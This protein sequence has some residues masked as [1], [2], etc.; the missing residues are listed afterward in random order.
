M[1]LMAGAALSRCSTQ[2][3]LMQGIS[4]LQSRASSSRRAMQGLMRMTSS[5]GRLH[6]G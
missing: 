3:V 2:P 4:S 6:G 1:L 5:P